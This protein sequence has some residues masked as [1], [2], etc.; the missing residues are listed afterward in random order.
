M[1]RA[2]RYISHDPEILGGEPVISGT[3]ITCQSVLGR[4]SGGETLEDLVRDYPDISKEAFE[5]AEIFARDNPP[6]RERETVR[7]WR[8]D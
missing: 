5:A 7:P 2:L 8:K 4:L 3:R 1:S 6:R